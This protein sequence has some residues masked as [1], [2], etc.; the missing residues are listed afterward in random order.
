MNY[1]QIL[2]I[3]FFKKN[4]IDYLDLLPVFKKV[5]KGKNLMLCKILIGI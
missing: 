5:G 1:P 4:E 3:D 2:L